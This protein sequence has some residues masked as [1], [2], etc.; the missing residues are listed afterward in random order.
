LV[1]CH[2]QGLSQAEAARQLGWPLGTLKGRLQRGH[3]LLRQRLQRRGFS[4]SVVGLTVGPAEQARAA[5]PAA[6]LRATVGCASP[7]TMP[8]RVAALAEGAVRALAAGRLKL[9]VLSALAA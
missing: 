1:L 9:A 7:A 4:L 6:L 8:A 2:L 5:V 3:R